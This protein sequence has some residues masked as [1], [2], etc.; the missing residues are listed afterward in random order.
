M[1]FCIFDT[2]TTGLFVFKDANGMPVPADDPCQ[3]RLAELGMI[4]LDENL[5]VE[6]EIEMYVQPDGWVMPPEAGKANWLTTEFLHENGAPV[7]DVL[8]QYIRV[9]DAG[10]TMV[11]FNAQFDLKMMRGE[12]RRAGMN[13]R[14]EQTKNICIMRAAMAIGVQKAGGG[15]GFPKLSDCMTHLGI[16]QEAAHTAGGDARSALALFRHLYETGNLPQARVHYAKTPPLH[17]EN[18]PAPIAAAAKMPEAF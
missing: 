15:R 11:A 10:Y 12:L 3:P 17:A 18:P 7:A 13:D 16:E 2:E 8:D 4:L 9:I 6:R 5:E 1:K 14:F